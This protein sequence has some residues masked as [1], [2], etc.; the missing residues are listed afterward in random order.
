MYYEKEKLI[1]P[2]PAVFA[3]PPMQI[4]CAGV[5]LL[6]ATAVLKKKTPP[7]SISARFVVRIEL[8]MLHSAPI[9]MHLKN[10]P[11]LQ[12]RMSTSTKT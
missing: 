6:S 2:A 10:P 12:D 5:E 3:S 7:R 1:A 8:A 4:G 9:P 11:A